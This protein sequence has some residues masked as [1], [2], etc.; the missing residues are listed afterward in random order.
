[1]ERA[2]GWVR[3]QGVVVKRGAGVVVRDGRLV[4]Q[5]RLGG[6]ANGRE[7]KRR[8]N[9]LTGAEG[10]KKRRN[11]LTEAPSVRGMMGLTGTEDDTDAN[12]ASRAE[13]L[14]D[15]A[16]WTW[17]AAKV[18]QWLDLYWDEWVMDVDGRPP[19]CSDKFLCV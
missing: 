8:S 7:K 16:S 13:V 9:S 18:A 2:G 3:L 11:S 4:R 6:E 14:K 5:V 10:E 1:M 19:W 17:P 15:F 12:N